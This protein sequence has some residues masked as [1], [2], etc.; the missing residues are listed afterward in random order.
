MASPL[1]PRPLGKKWIVDDHDA[2]LIPAK[3]GIH[4]AACGFVQRWIPA[5]AGMSGYFI[6]RS[7]KKAPFGT[8]FR[9]G[10]IPT[11]WISR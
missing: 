5:F 8:K 1:F 11:K 9:W 2:P 6:L 4:A 3:A 7:P 10:P